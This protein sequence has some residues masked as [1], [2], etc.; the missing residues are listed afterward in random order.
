MLVV[1]MGM[2][3]SLAEASSIIEGS[4]RR[5]L[6]LFE[7]KER[8]IREEIEEFER[9]YAT[10]SSEFM[11]KFERGDLGDDQD[12]FEWWGLIRGLKTVREQMDKIRAVLSH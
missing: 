5:E 11:E 8:L 7:M 9:K 2:D 4:L 6:A 10:S 3:S 12:Y 1:L